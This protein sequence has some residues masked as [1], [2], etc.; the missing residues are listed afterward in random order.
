MTIL[1]TQFAKNHQDAAKD[2][3]SLLQEGR[4]LGAV[5][6]S[7][8]LELICEQYTQLAPS[9]AYLWIDPNA[10]QVEIEEA[11]LRTFRVEL[12]HFLRNVLSLAPLIAT[13]FALFWAV[14]N[15]QKDLALNAG[16][17]NLPFLELWQTGFNGLTWFTFT[18]AAALDVLLLSLYLLSILIAH[19]VER[20]AHN[21]AMNY[22]RKLQDKVE[23]LVNYVAAEGIYHVGDQ[24]DIDKVTDAIKKVVNEATDA[25]KLFVD[26]ANAA[27]KVAT[28]NLEQSFKTLM[29]GVQSSV[30]QVVDA[31]TQSITDSNNKVEGLFTLQVVPLMTDFR[32]DMKTLHTELGNYQGRLTDLTIASQ[33]LVGASQGLAGASQVL[34][35]NADRYVAI[36]QDIGAQIASLNATQ[37]EVLTGIQT[38]AGGIITAAGNMTNATTN[39]ITATRMVEGVANHLDAGV[40]MA[41]KTMTDNVNNATQGLLYVGPRLEQTASNLYSAAALLAS[42][43]RNASRF[44]WPFGRRGNQAGRPNV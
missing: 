21:R 20:R 4:S 37:Q 17:R 27:N 19:Q 5:E 9:T 2:L 26:K 40:K 16:D 22:M 39:M 43:Q 29:A 7:K 41:M 13:W 10:I 12:V 33:Q 8:R 1:Q 42:I 30:K 35:D 24:A 3:G 14:Y 11:Q 25:F 32:Q 6:G 23:V 28:D 44:P 18:V 36:G 38:V 34:T 15:Y 31:S